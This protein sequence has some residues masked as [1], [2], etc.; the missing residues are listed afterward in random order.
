MCDQLNKYF[1]EMILLFALLNFSNAVAQHEN[2]TIRKGN[3]LYGEKKFADAE[4]KYKQALQKNKNSKEA[5]FNLGD[6]IYE[7]KK[8]EE[9]AEQF[10]AAAKTSSNKKLQSQA[11]HNLGNAYLKNMRRVSMHTNKH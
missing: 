8:F 5:Q 11:Y 3:E 9:A 2:K 1:F 4:K 6:A 7:Q 10:S